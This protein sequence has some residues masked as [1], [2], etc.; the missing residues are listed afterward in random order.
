MSAR[1]KVARK[2]V[3]KVAAKAPATPK[4]AEG[5]TKARGG[6]RWEG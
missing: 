3:K 4:W 2:V 6:L 5:L 1:K